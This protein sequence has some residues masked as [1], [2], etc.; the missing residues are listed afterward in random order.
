LRRRE[1]GFFSW[2]KGERER[3]PPDELPLSKGAARRPSFLSERRGKREGSKLG[4]FGAEAEEER[5]AARGRG[6]K[7]GDSSASSAL[8]RG[9]G[10]K[11]RASSLLE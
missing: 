6:E 10:G 1:D 11:E 8:L 3:S 4:L 7:G 2:K 9:K 5:Q